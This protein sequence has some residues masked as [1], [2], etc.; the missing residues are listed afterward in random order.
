MPPFFEKNEVVCSAKSF[1]GVGVAA[2]SRMSKFVWPKNADFYKAVPKA[3]DL[4][5]AR[6]VYL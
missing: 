5:F 6:A 3:A 1:W 2:D 4:I